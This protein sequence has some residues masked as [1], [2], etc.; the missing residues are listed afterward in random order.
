MNGIETTIERAAELFKVPVAAITA[1]GK[2]KTPRVIC[3]REWV[4]H[5]HPE[6][7]ARALAKAMGYSNHTVILSARKR[8]GV[9]CENTVDTDFVG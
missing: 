5:R 4:I 1:G 9:D 3:A 6:I 2:I 8:L 7:S